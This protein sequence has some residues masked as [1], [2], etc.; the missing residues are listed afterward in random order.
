MSIDKI[1][2]NADGF[3]KFVDKGRRWRISPVHRG[4]K[5][6]YDIS[7]ERVMNHYHCVAQVSRR[8]V[9]MEVM[10]YEMQGVYGS[11]WLGGETWAEQD[12]TGVLW[13]FDDQLSADN[14]MRDVHA[15]ES[16]GMEEADAYKED[17]LRTERRLRETIE[18]GAVYQ[19]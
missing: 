6:L 4:E 2:R 3:D 8:W 1:L 12:C 5:T 19:I 11:Q 17:A 9:V 7:C 18:S 15:W 13:Y 14:A 16:M 10:T